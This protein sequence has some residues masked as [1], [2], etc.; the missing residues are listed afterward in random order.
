MIR[1][2]TF[3]LAQLWPNSCS[4]MKGKLPF[5]LM[6]RT[7]HI[8]MVTVRRASKNLRVFRKG[9]HSKCHTFTGVCYLWA[10]FA[11]TCLQWRIPAK[12][13]KCLT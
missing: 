2:G 5:A 8:D 11:L 4:P 12:G 3:L 6:T 9:K 10:P 7:C 13:D 1:S